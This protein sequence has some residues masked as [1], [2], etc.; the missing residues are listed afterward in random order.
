MLTIKLAFRNIIGAG[1]RTWLNVFI[2]SIAFLTIIWVQGVLEGFNK[3][4]M[5]AMI[6]MELGG[7]QFWYKSYDRYDPLTIE[8]AHG[9]VSEALKTLIDTDQATPILIT[10][11]AVFPEGRVQSVLLKGIDPA[12]KVIHIPSHILQT[13]DTSLIPA[14]IGS[15]MARETR[16][17]EG[18]E[19]T[20]RWRDIHGTFDAIDIQ[21]AGIMNTTVQSVDNN[22]IWLPLATLREMIQAPDQATLVVLG[23]NITY[24]P[25]DD[26]L[27][28]YRDLN[29]LL[30]DL[31]EFIRT[32][33]SGTSIL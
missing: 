33:S 10:S 3:Q 1:L 12:Q 5:D 13:D 14:L 4:A 18:S 15:R 30:Q 26:A 27:W 7:G 24:I 32:K 28:I 8:D 29:Y 17:K 2:L 6:D 22:Q 9:P 16:L 31:K 21:I 23:K 19:V 11:G 25:K 20:I